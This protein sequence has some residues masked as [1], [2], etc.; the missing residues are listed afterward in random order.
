MNTQKKNF[1]KV[2]A[3]HRLLAE[4]NFSHF[5]ANEQYH[6]LPASPFCKDVLTRA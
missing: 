3:Q 2:M 1:A 5:H 4:F 6:I